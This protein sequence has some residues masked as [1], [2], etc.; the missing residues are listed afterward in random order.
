MKEPF[1]EFIEKTLE[2]GFLLIACGLPGTW[3]TETCEEVAR[4]KGYL[5]LRTDLIRRSR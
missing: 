3:K 4:I 1:A 2:P 5:I